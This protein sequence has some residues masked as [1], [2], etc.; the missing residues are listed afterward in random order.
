M[1]AAVFRRGNGVAAGRRL[2][3]RLRNSQAIAVLRS[4]AHQAGHRLTREGIP[5]RGGAA[6][7]SRVVPAC[8]DRTA[9]SAA[10]HA[11]E[12]A[13]EASGDDRV[14]RLC[15]RADLVVFAKKPSDPQ[16][17]LAFV[18][19]CGGARASS[20]PANSASAVSPEAAAHAIAPSTDTRLRGP[21]AGSVVVVRVARLRHRRAPLGCAVHSQVKGRHV[22]QPG[23][24]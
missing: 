1:G 3:G 9:P 12:P 6:Q 10:A 22:E 14:A 11:D 2:V 23:R 13:Y 8:R 15:S 16:G 20:W 4:Q 17:R 24:R 21:G 5:A 18:T 7:R 19:A